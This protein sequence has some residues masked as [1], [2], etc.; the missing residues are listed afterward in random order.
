MGVEVLLLAGIVL[1]HRRA[2]RVLQGYL[3]ILLSVGLVGER[4][5]IGNEVID[6]IQGLPVAQQGC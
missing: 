3:S 6:L 1:D 2:H 5:F 4:Y